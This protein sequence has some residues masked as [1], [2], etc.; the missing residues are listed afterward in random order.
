MK[1]MFDEVICDGV[2]M[3]FQLQHLRD[4]YELWEN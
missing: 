3:E 2:V 1:Y 4:S